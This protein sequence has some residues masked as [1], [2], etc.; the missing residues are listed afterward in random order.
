[1][2]TFSDDIRAAVFAGI[3]ATLAAA[4]AGA[5][6]INEF[7]VPT[8]GVSPAGITAG[9]D[10]DLWFTELEGNAV[11]RITTAGTVVNQF[12][13]A[14]ALSSPVS[15]G[16]T[17]GPDGNLWFAAYEGNQ[18]GR[19]TTAGAVTL[20]DVPT[21]QAG[22]AD[23]V[24]GPDGN[25]WFTELNASKIGRITTTGAFKE[26][27]VPTGGAGPAGIAVGPDG[28]LWFTEEN[29]A[30][31]GRLTT[32]GVFHEFTLPDADAQPEPAPTGITLGPD[33]N[34]W[35]TELSGNNVGRITPA[36]VITDFP[37]PTATA[38]SVFITAGP[39]GNLWFT[40]FEANQIG[41]VTTAGKV[42]EYPVPT[43]HSNP[44]GITAGPDGNIWFTEVSGNKVGRVELPHNAACVATA[45]TLC[46]DDKPG[47]K[48][49]QI[50]IA[51]KTAQSGG[52]AGNGQAIPLASLGV[53]EGGLFWFFD[54]D[55]P[56]MLIK[57]INA[58]S[59]NQHFWL[60]YSATTNVGFTVTVKDTKTSRTKTYQNTDET[61]APPQ[62]DTAAFTCNAQGD[63][64][65][66]A[67]DAAVGDVAAATSAHLE[68]GDQRPA[69]AEQ[70]LPPTA[71]DALPEAATCTANGTTLCIDGRFQITATYKTA[72]GGGSAGN[73]HAIALNSLGVAQGGLFWFFSANNPEMLIK[74]I[75]GCSINQKYWLFY[76]AGT[77][78]G[79][80]AVVT[81]LQTGAHKS[82]ANTDGTAAAPVQDTAAL[83]CS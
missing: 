75:D 39:D 31:V 8:S 28:N 18:I 64:A 37:L 36:G 29:T 76:A 20:F 34:L 16:I 77:N 45:T 73:G 60:F 54:A 35:F 21:S 9:P 38:G 44:G 25:L 14:S 43:A 50:G 10:G 26:F 24:A 5:I 42:T 57:V 79:F 23:I 62:Q 7:P 72:E 12:P 61:A 70:N 40:E 2:A 56:E 49:W 71:I 22:P 19:I 80:T 17:V 69:S 47:D 66:P 3:L 15:G 41:M 68:A 82:Y 83:P 58:C 11:G 55:N 52:L 67:P 81:D 65:P 33:G 46:I 74:V 51:Y 13:V 32:A 78:V 1:M 27:V 6:T 59:V 48:R 4:P 30:K 63:A 53:T